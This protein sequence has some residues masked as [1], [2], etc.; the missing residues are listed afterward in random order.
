[1]RT[2]KLFP[3][4]LLAILCVIATS[5]TAQEE[6]SEPEFA[7][8][9]FKLI[10]GLGGHDM[11]SDAETEAGRSVQL[12]L[13][14]GFNDAATLWLSLSGTELSDKQENGPITELNGGGLTF[15]YKFWTRA[16]L[17][18]Y[19]KVGIEGAVLETR[20]SN[21]RRS[22]GGLMFAVGTDYFFTRRLGLGVE[23]Q[24]KDIRFV[25]QEETTAQ[26]EVEADIRP[27]LNRDTLGFV[28]TFTLQ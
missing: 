15:Q 18:P 28:V 22:G 19:S 12:G 14:Y 4:C 16:S 25:R 10:L 2:R 6:K 20:G 1:M 8:K 9:G 24:F 7:H 26:G 3:I 13:G 5:A 27:E 11:L 23:V 21:V 17:Q